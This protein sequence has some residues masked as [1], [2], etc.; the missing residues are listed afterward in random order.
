METTENKREKTV[1]ETKAETGK[2]KASKT[3][4][5][6]GHPLRACRRA[7]VPLV[8][9]ET[10]DPSETMRSI[11]AIAGGVP[12]GIP[13][14]TWDISSNLSTVNKEHSRIIGWYDALQHPLPEILRGIKTMMIEKDGQSGLFYVFHGIG[15]FFDRDGVTQAIWNLRDSLKSTRS[16][17][18]MVGPVIKLPVELASDVVVIQEPM[19]GIVE[20]SEVAGTILKDA[21]LA[22]ADIKDTDN[23]DAIGKTLL[24]LSRFTAE[25]SV[26][27][28]VNRKGVDYSALWERKKQFV[29]QTDG[30]SIY[31]GEED[32]STIGGLEHAKEILSKTIQGKLGINCIVF[33]DEIDKAMA[34]ASTD[35]SGVSQDQNRTLLSY[36]QDN[37]VVGM[38]FLGPPGTGKTQIC[39]AAG[40]QHKI[41][42]IQ[43]DMGATKGGLVGESERKVR[44]ALSVIHAVSLGKALFIGACNRADGLPP[45]L[46]RRFSYCSMFMDLPTQEER[47]VMWKIWKARYDITQPV[48]FDDTGWTGSEIRN[49]TM[50]SWAMDCPLSEAATSIVPVSVSARDTID[51]LRQQASGKYVSASCRGVYQYQTKSSNVSDNRSESARIF[52]NFNQ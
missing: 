45:E 25:Q 27:M 28:S 46:R 26:A 3:V 33:I 5:I 19:P 6:P 7:S 37:D 30:L 44:Q 23:P 4:P 50:K 32:Y 35:L 1:K 17:L 22:G 2:T 36:I 49:C 29:N 16:M 34:A 43:L 9:I 31:Q 40:A 8:Y 42:I 38:L 48:D 47:Q 14:V 10:I 24:G 13:I 21:K 39:K 52:D 15:K 12:N 18:I 41:P 20:L 51:K 11:I